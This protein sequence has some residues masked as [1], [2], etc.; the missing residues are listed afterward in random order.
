MARGQTQY[1]GLN[2]WEAA[3]QVL[4]TEFNADNQKID[5]ALKAMRD[6]IVSPSVLNAVLDKLRSDI[7]ALSARVDKL[8]G[9]SREPPEQM[10]RGAVKLRESESHSNQR[11]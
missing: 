8:E 7:N 2:Q 11:F 6:L 4:R 10:L 5:G 3:D 1:Y 9:K